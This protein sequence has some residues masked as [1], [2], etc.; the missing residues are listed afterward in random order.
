MIRVPPRRFTVVGRPVLAGID[1]EKCKYSLIVTFSEGLHYGLSFR[2]SVMY[3]SSLSDKD[4][5]GDL[6]KHAF[7]EGRIRIYT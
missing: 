5:P 3:K 1:H 6:Y 7:G 4:I 2:V